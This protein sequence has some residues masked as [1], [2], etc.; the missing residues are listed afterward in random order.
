MAFQTARDLAQ[1]GGFM[2]LSDDEWAQVL[3]VAHRTAMGITRDP[4][5]SDD[6]AASTVERLL[7]RNPDIEDGRL[8]AYAVQVARHL[9]IDELRRVQRQ[10]RQ[11]ELEED[12]KDPAAGYV[13]LAMQQMSP[14]TAALRGEMKRRCNEVAQEIL[15]SLN[16]REI[17]LLQLSIDGVP[18]AEIAI[19]LGY[20]DAN[21][22]NVTRHRINRKIRERFSHRISPSLFAWA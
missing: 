12:P 5:L 17:R 6:I 7:E 11:A 3:D 20:A 16:E 4:A 14:S 15:G 8:L 19:K 9:T 1:G 13:I 2:Q 21:T 18:S 22:V 10:P